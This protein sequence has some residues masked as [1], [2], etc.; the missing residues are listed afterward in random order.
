MDFYLELFDRLGHGLPDIAIAWD[1]FKPV[2]HPE[3]FLGS[4]GT[5]IY[6][7]LEWNWRLST[8]VGA[9]VKKIFK[10]LE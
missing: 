7:V 3:Y 10:S 1:E 4:I 8:M 2:L 6:C 5:Y 9:Y